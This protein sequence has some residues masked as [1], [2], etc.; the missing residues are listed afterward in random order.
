MTAYAPADLLQKVIRPALLRIGLGSPAA[1]MLLIGTCAQES[2]MG[3]Y[4]VQKGGGPALGIFQMEPNT[5]ADIWASFL[6][7]RESLARE[8]RGMLA[9]SD[10]L[11]PPL[12]T[13]DLYACAMAR[14]EFDRA[15]PPLPAFGDLDAMAD[16]Y[17]RFY[18]R[19]GKAT[20]AEFKTNF[21]NACP[22]KVIAELWPAPTP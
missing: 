6:I 19:G 2:R 22:A 21:Q 12:R 8:I 11:I 5:A 3:L 7:Y 10:D 14:V 16:Y 1:E 9:A 18:N 13:N 20:A 4:R 17:L 15:K